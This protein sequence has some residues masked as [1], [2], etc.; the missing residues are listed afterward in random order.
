MNTGIEL[1]NHEVKCIEGSV[2]VHNLDNNTVVQLNGTGGIMFLQLSHMLRN[3][4]LSVDT[5]V[6]S[7]VSQYPD[8]QGREDEVIA[9]FNCLLKEFLK[10]GLLKGVAD[11]NG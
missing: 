11:G 6:K 3:G 1:S 9:D 5:I 4:G 10:M 2:L 8:M 7:I